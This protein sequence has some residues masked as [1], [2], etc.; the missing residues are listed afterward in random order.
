MIDCFLLHIKS[1]R[2][3]N[4]SQWSV[5]QWQSACLVCLRLRV[6]FPA[7]GRGTPSSGTSSKQLPGSW[8]KAS[9]RKWRS[10]K[11]DK[12]WV[13]QAVRENGREGKLGKSTGKRRGPHVLPTCPP[14]GDRNL[15]SLLSAILVR[16]LQAGP[17]AFCYPWL[18]SWLPT[19]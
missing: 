5:T 10:V 12:E 17:L 13:D 16:D 7:L 9:W 8:R 19:S 4:H 1:I 11:G 14:S 18:P 3:R 6:P 15:S 2:F